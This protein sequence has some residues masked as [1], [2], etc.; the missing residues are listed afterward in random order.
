MTPCRTPDL[1]QPSLSRGQRGD[2]ARRPY[3]G[4]AARAAAGRSLFSLPGGVVETGET[5]PRR[6]PAR[7]RGDRLSIEPVALAGFRE[8]IAAT[9]RRVERHFVIL[10]FAA[11]WLAGEPV[12]NEELSEARWV[13]PAELAGLPTTPASPRSWRRR[14]S[15][16]ARRAEG[17]S[18]RRKAL[19]ARRET[20]IDPRQGDIEDDASSSKRRSLLS[21]AGSLLAEI[22]LP[23]LAV[24]WM[25]LIVFPGLMLGVAPIVAS[26]WFNKL[27]TG[28]HRRWRESGLRSC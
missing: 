8:T 13:R 3:P 10:C 11:R 18:K 6:S 27:S 23:K 19:E 14:S 17:S 1:S 12:L 24:A 5:L 9:R 4:G 28:L 26:I 7:S 20:K 15:G 16:S 25:L 2:R 21:L 22:S